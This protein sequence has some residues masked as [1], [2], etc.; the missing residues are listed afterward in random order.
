VLEESPK[1][2][3]PHQDSAERALN[4]L[5]RTFS[6]QVEALKRC[7]A[8]VEPNVTVQHVS[9]ESSGQ[10]VVGNVAP[11]LAPATPAN[12]AALPPAGTSKR[13]ELR[14]VTR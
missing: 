8:R 6:T 4:N 9:V 12:T 3:S 5:A 14:V 13:P 2:E 11:A 7:R 10:T 1:E